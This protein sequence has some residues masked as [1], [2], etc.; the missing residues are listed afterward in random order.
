MI[1]N[2][3]QSQTVVMYLHFLPRKTSRALQKI[4]LYAMYAEHFQKH[5]SEIVY[6]GRPMSSWTGFC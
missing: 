1:V 5:G 2:F 6:T 4:T 3:W